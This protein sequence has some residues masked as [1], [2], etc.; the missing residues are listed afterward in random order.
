MKNLTCK[1]NKIHN[2]LQ[3]EYINK[4]RIRILSVVLHDGSYGREE[5]LFEIMPHKCPKNWGDSVKGRCTF[6]EVQKW[7]NKLDKDN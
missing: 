6:G 3:W 5:G 4:N 2:G 1:L 7:I